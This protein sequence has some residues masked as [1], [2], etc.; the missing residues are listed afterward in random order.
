MARPSTVFMFS[1]QG[2]QHFHMGAA[3]FESDPRFRQWLLRLDETARPLV[4]SSVVE[5][6]YSASRGKADPFERTLLS[7]PAIF[8]VE[9]ALAQSLIGAG[10]EPDM[11][12]GVSVGSFA[13]AAVA[14]FIEA[15]AA[16][17]LVIRQAQA[18]EQHAEPGGMI[19]VLAAPE[20]FREEFLARHSE[21]A[22][23]NFAA[24]FVVSA[25]RLHLAQIEDALRA[26]DMSYQRLPVSFPFH[27]RWMDGARQPF[28][29]A[30][31]EDVALGR[32]PLACC[33]RVEALTSLPQGFFW[34]V[35]RRPIRFREMA[36][37]LET[38]GAHR[39][40]DVGPAGTLATLLKYGLSAQTESSVHAILTPFGFDARNL[41]RLLTASRNW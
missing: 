32:L 35:V 36:A 24:H 38:R 19:A 11:T 20:L 3:L 15:Q 21:L 4:G 17:G 7:H 8:M 16:L 28:E 1:G 30:A 2:S 41:E 31:R 6:I 12:L 29:A 13:A 37:R 14:G 22:A 10:I 33:D 34:D 5:A 27:S 26:R 23:V 9:Y 40:V 18:L 25:P 39:Y